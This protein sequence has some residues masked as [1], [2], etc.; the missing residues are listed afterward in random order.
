MSTLHYLLN[1][2]FNKWKAVLKNKAYLKK[3]KVTLQNSGERT[4]FSIYG[5]EI[6]GSQIRFPGKQIVR[7]WDLG[8][9]GKVL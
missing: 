1:F 9:R 2:F 3:N 4:A 6:V 5:I 8:T 7:C